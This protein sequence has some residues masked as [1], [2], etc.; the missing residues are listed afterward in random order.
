MQR[1][2]KVT[3]LQM[4]LFHCSLTTMVGA[5]RRGAVEDGAFAASAAAFSAANFLDT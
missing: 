5:T 1:R 2:E 3:A 4:K